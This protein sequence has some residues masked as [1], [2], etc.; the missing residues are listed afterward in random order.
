MNAKSIKGT[1]PDE[2]KSALQQ[3][4]TDGFKPTLAIVFLSPKQDRDSITA[5][6]DK[7]GIAVFGV[8]T[9]GE[10]TGEGITEKS[11]AILLLDMNRDFFTI[12][13]SEFPEKN[14][15]QTFE[16]C[17]ESSNDS[18]DEPLMILNAKNSL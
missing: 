3:S 7:A 14:Y 6:L 12:T 4:I 10:F 15:R 16:T 11:V 13:F 17:D 2:I 9:H 5:L 8:T 1:S 18:S